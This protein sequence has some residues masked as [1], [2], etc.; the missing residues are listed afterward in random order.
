MK[1][2]YIIIG[3][4]VSGLTCASALS[5]M[6]KKVL[7]L[8]KNEETGGCMKNLVWEENGTQRG[9]WTLGMQ[10]TLAYDKNSIYNKLLQIFTD[11][12]C[13]FSPVDTKYQ[14]IKFSKWGGKPGASTPPPTPYFDYTIL[15]DG[16]KM[17][18]QLIKDFPEEKRAIKRYYR[19]MNAISRFA[20]IL[21]L[22][23]YLPIWLA[24]FLYPIILAIF[25]PVMSI[26]LR[27]FSKIT[28]QDVVENRYKIKDEKLRLI[29]Y[30]YWHLEGM[31]VKTV[32]FLF[33]V[34]ATKMLEKGVYIP[35]GGA[36]SIRNAFLET[37]EKNG[38]ETRVNTEVKNIIIEKNVA[39]GIKLKDDTIIEA[40]KIISTAGVPE[41]IGRLINK[42]DWNKKVTQ[43][44]SEAEKMKEYRSGLVLRVGLKGDISKL[45]FTKSTL[46]TQIGES[47]EMLGNPTKEDWLPQD[48]SYSFLSVIDQTV[49]SSKGYNTVDVIC[50]SPYHYFEHLELN[51]PEYEKIE[52]R[53]TEILID[54][55]NKEFPGVK[56]LVAFTHLTSPLTV[57]NST[58]HSKGNIDGLNMTKSGNMNIQPHTGIKNLY[59]SGMDMFSQGITTFDGILTVAASEGLIKT[60]WNMWKSWR[61]IKKVRK[62]TS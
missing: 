31:A 49:D 15:A 9:N 51:S 1:Y 58:S 39:K 43:I 17:R 3:S 33:Y 59:F 37:I 28:L 7:L 42:N 20:P 10:F 16:A 12:K 52:K 62:Q 54:S 8:E 4:G 50:F 23:K 46:K 19:N 47:S 60:S 13:E 26:R 25:F 56:E 38:V 45:G 34:V 14:K 27:K 30:S 53:I 44:M 24:S 11:D 55:F 57:K 32:P 35:N 40:Q 41:T 21:A 2:D 48:I 29:I 18:D 6:N 36:V 22:P 5:Q 61:K